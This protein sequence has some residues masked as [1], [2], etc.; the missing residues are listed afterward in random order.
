MRWRTYQWLKALE[1]AC[2]HSQARLSARP[3]RALRFKQ[4]NRVVLLTSYCT[5]LLT[6]RNDPDNPNPNQAPPAN[7]SDAEVTTKG[8]ARLADAM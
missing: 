3:T 7:A 5:M 1:V 8:D 2:R 6:A 4:C